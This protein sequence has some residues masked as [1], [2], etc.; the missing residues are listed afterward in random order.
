MRKVINGP[1]Q[2]DRSPP[3]RTDRA[4]PER[5]QHE[6]GH[7]PAPHGPG[8]AREMSSRNAKSRGGSASV[9]LTQKPGPQTLQPSGLVQRHRSPGRGERR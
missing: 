4:A 3:R 6:S 5:A 8:V 1:W 7:E 9:E 2:P